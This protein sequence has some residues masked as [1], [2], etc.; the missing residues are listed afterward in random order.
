[1]EVG[2]HVVEDDK[3]LLKGPVRGSQVAQPDHILVAEVAEELDL[4][5]DALCRFIGT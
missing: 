5:E 2:V 3:E 1:M 4:A